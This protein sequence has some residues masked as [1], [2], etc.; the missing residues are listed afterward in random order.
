MAPA[1]TTRS[2]GA[3]RPRCPTILKTITNPC[4][5]LADESGETRGPRSPRAYDA[6]A[7][8]KGCVG[9]IYSMAT[10]LKSCV[11]L[12]NHSGFHKKSQKGPS[13]AISSTSVVSASSAHSVIEDDS[14]VEP[15]SPEPPATVCRGFNFH[16][17]CLSRTMRLRQ[18][19]P[20]FNS[21]HKHPRMPRMTEIAP[22]LFLIHTR[23]F[24]ISY[25]GRPLTTPAD[26]GCALVLGFPVSRHML[27]D[28]P[29][30]LRIV[31]DNGGSRFLLASIPRMPTCSH[32]P[33]HAVLRSCHAPDCHLSHEA[34]SSFFLLSLFI[35]G[36]LTVH[37]FVSP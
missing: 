23:V 6:H 2:K 34:S 33:L 25:Y 32:R 8:S 36:N 21:R 7:F 15:S 4:A 29:A 5:A 27:L 1:D 14:S 19:L 26:I 17:K 35:G 12:F 28:M 11:E 10:N 22:E 13:S 3:G 20:T 24:A 30:S 37:P 16:L 31:V 18:S 9:D